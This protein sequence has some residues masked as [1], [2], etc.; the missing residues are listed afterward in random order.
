MKAT[1]LRQ[2]LRFFDPQKPL[3]NEAEL[4][5]WFVQRPRSPRLRLRTLLE[6]RTEVGDPH[7]IL[8]VGHRGSGKT[9]ELNK[10]RAEIDASYHTI[11]FDVLDVTGRTTLGY[12]DLMLA[13]STR[14]TQD[15]IEHD[16][17]PQPVSRPL[18]EGWQRL[19]DY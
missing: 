4:R 3:E 1:D 16:L 13:V 8:L 10:L 9:T 5:E 15:C 17:I 18:R 6:S 7:K 12:E 11:G 14:V 2:T 19:Q